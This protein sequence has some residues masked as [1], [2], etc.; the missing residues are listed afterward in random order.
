MTPQPHRGAAR[1]PAVLRRRPLSPGA[2]CAR[3]WRCGA[4]RPP[5]VTRRHACSHTTHT[6]REENPTPT[7]RPGHLCLFP[8]PFYTPTL[9]PFHAASRPVSFTGLL[10]SARLHTWCLQGRPRPAAA[11]GPPPRPPPSAPENQPTLAALPLPL[12]RRRRG[13]CALGC[14]RFG[15]AQAR[16]ARFWR[17]RG[18]AGALPWAQALCPLV[19]AP[20]SRGRA[21]AGSARAAYMHTRAHALPPPHSTHPLTPT[22][23]PRKKE[24]KTSEGPRQ[25]YTRSPH[26]F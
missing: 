1:E 20:C 23:F 11:A 14:R 21:F 7:P 8:T 12:P 25:A 9:A 10:P 13:G 2:P 17:R 18:K 3:T 22:P 19:T 26:A 24:K 4:K 16:L 6:P 15:C 5:P